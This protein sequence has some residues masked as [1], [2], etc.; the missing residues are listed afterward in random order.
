MRKKYLTN[1]EYLRS[2]QYKDSSNLDARIYLHENFST[3]KLGFYRWTFEHIGA[4]KHQRILDLG[5]GPGDLWVKNAAG[6][7]D[8]W[9]ITLSDLS[10][11]MLERARSRLMAYR[12]SFPMTAADAQ[13]IPFPSNQFDTVIANHMLYHVPN[14]DG[15][16]SEIHR[17]LRPNGRLVAATNGKAHM[18]ALWKMIQNLDPMNALGLNE[19]LTTHE[20]PFSLENGREQIEKYFQKVSIVRYEDSLRVAHS[21]PL[22]DYVLSMADVADILRKHADKLE[23]FRAAI[24]DEICT[25]GAVFIAK[26]PGIFVAE[27]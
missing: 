10:T 19:A 12:I 5:C 24:N 6:I 13:R 2:E 3:N 7:P 22:I 17:I 18:Q 15:A 16:L 23:E 8:H 26:D 9:T 20:L 4:Q 25:R 1:P 14:R 21:Q 27:K 11:G